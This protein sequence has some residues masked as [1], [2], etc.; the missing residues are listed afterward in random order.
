MTEG[1]GIYFE[2]HRESTDL[3]RRALRGGLVSLV[4]QYGNAVFQIVASIVLARLLSPE[5]FGLVAIVTVLTSFAPLLIDFGLGDATAQRSNITPSQVSSL[6]WLSTAIGC[7]VAVAVA[8]GSPLIASIYAEPRLQPIALSIAV[9]FVL[10]G[11]SV[12]HLALLRRTMQFGAIGRIQI[13]G[14]LAG[15]VAAIAMAL[16][17][18][19]Y[20]ALVLRPIAN[21]LFVVVGAWSVCRWRPGYPVF[22]K[23]VSSLV[24]FGLNVV[25]FSVTYTLAKSSDRL[26]LGLVYRP[27]QVGY[28]QNAINLYENSIQMGLVQVH[29]VGSTALSKL[30]S[31]PAGLRDKYVL[32]LS[33]VAYFVMP[34]AS[35]LSVTGKDLTVILL[36]EKWHAAGTLL[37]IIALKGIFHVIE[38][39]QGWL[40]LSIGTADRWQRWGLVATAVLVASVLVGLPFGPTG[41]AAAIVV[42][43]MLN[44]LPSVVYAGRPIGIDAALVVRAVYRQL[45]GAI[46][47]AA[48]GWWIETMV[49]PGYSIFVRVVLAGSFCVCIYLA[50]VVG[51]FRFVQPIRVAR[52]IVKDLLGR[53]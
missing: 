39:S 27:D 33:V 1:A 16:Y 42:A 44:A 23:D 9:T 41:V 11:M 40:H 15:M 45:T 14:T 38:S 35:I 49:L 25:G 17:G 48:A 6:F 36:G 8:A 28:Y 37:S 5:D 52:S 3:G 7:V 12:Q 53:R 26:A 19:G 34:M 50:V 30:Q 20:W 47:T 46:V 24:R 2:E 32:G 4:M 29:R 10:S 51:L 21:S 43:C 13:L 31:N 18:Y 22:D